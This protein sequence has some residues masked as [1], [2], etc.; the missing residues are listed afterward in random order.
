LRQFVPSQAVVRG[1]IHPCHPSLVL[2]LLLCIDGG[3]SSVF[4]AGVRNQL[5]AGLVLNPVQNGKCSEM[6]L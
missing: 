1:C 3:Y 4:I 6:L 2:A 5:G